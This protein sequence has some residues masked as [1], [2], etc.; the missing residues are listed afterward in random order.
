MNITDRLHHAK[1]L[2]I[3]LFDLPSDYEHNPELEE[4]IAPGVWLVMSPDATAADH[5]AAEAFRAKVT[6]ETS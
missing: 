1:R 6:A 4:E 2:N 3:S 5:A